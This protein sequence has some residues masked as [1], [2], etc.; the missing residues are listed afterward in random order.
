M[1]FIPALQGKPAIKTG[2]IGGNMLNLLCHLQVDLSGQDFSHVTLWQADLRQAILHNVDFTNADLSRSTFTNTFGNVLSIAFNPDGAILAKS[3]EQGWIS[4]W[5]VETGKQLLSFKAHSNWIFSVAFS[6]ADVNLPSGSGAMLAS[7]GLDRSVKLW[8]LNTGECL[9]TFQMHEGGISA[10]SILPS[11]SPGYCSTSQGSGILAS[12][13]ADQTIKLIDLETGECLH[14][15]KG[16]QGIVR[17]ISS[18]PDYQILASASLDQTIR[19]WDVASGQCL[20]TI[21]DSTTIYSIVFIEVNPET[22]KQQDRG[23]GKDGKDLLPSSFPSLLASAG[24]DGNVKLWD[25]TTGECVKVLK[26]HSDRV[27]SLA[28]SP[29]GK[30]LVSGS[31]DKT[32]KIWDVAT[33]QCLK[34]LYGH[35]NRIWSVAFSSDGQTFASGSNDRTIRLWNI[36]TGQ[37]LRTLQGYNNDT[38]PIGF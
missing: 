37:C 15:L 19:L 35:Q 27:W 28:A 20:K 1:H 33:G 6:P 38:A 22:R 29:M 4:I 23:N 16:H 31:D 5:Q 25:T 17:S 18:S 12:S 34:T 36:K 21:V 24:D 3:D 8:D 9:R 11:V 2:Y 7:G 26:G 13:S 10:V 30:I 32:I 14:T